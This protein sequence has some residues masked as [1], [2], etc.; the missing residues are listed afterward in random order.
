[1]GDHPT[2][3]AE[4]T[5]SAGRV[6]VGA[7]VLRD[8]VDGP[9][10]QG[11]LGVGGVTCDQDEIVASVDQAR[12]VPLVWPGVGTTRTRSSAVNE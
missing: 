7:G 6:A 12:Q 10:Q 8:P 11:V 9:G 4:F 2:V 3:P 5:Q 1:M